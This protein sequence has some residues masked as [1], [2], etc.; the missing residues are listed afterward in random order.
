MSDSS[1]DFVQDFV[2]FSRPA[3]G[4]EEEDAAIR[5]LRSGWLTT[6]NEALEF[7]K[8]FARYAGIPHALSVNSATSGIMLALDAVGVGEGDAVITT[9]YTFV[10]TALAA[11]HLGADVY[12]ADIE[13]GSYGISPNEIEKQL[14][15]HKN[16]RA[17]IPVHIAGNVCDMRAINELAKKHGVS[18]VEDAAHAF[19]S[20]TADGFAGTLGDAGVFSFYATKTITTGEGGMIAVK[21]GDAAKRISVMRMHG[22]D[23]PVWNRYTQRGASW[24]YDVVEAGFKCN[25]PDILA[26]VGREQ[27]KKAEAFFDGRKKIVSRYNEAF[28][29]CDF[30]RLP[31]DGEGNAW[32]L[33]LIRIVPEK[34]SAGR[35]EFA[36]AL[37]EKGI[38]VSM[39]FIPHFEMTWFKKRYGIRAEDFPRAAQK[40]RTTITLPLWPGMTD[41]QCA[42]VIDAVKETGN[43]LYRR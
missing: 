19:P 5:V 8:E 29:D 7:E 10:S 34:L 15:A 9:P 12:Y 13:E 43:R 23:R 22:I 42:R 26:A 11:V 24:E 41:E 18:V 20:R 25:L 28:S 21:D 2:P 17:V 6:G 32:H 35:D 38:G 40:A 39:H 14:A 31:P 3:I 16:V 4:K 37:Q 1:R 33:Y 27:L 36:A 30:L